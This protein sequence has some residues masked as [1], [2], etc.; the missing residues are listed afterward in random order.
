LQKT[1]NPL[2]KTGLAWQLWKDSLKSPY[3]LNRLITSPTPE[4]G[5]IVVWKWTASY[6]GHVGRII[7]IIKT[8]F[9]QLVEFNTSNGMYGSQRE[10]DGVFIRTRDLTKPLM[11]NSKHKGNLE[12]IGLI[13]FDT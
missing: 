1:K 4:I 3:R 5:D 11:R 12:V 10:G 13:G 2:S 6:Q 9:V 7:N 8:D